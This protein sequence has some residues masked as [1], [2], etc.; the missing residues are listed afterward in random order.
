MVFRRIARAF[1]SD[2]T[3]DLS[4]FKG[5]FERFQKIL[6]GNNRVLEIMSEL[7]DKL[8][9]DYIFDINYLKSITDELSEEVN[10]IV[11]NLNVITDNRNQE[12]FPRQASVQEELRSI[13]HGSAAP[14]EKEY[15]IEYGGVD[16]DITEMVGGKNARLGEIKNQ[17]KMA[18]PDGFVLTTSAFRRFM[19]FN[20]LWPEI[21]RIHST[22]WGEN[23]RSA[24]KYDR[25]V[26][27]LFAGTKLP[28]EVARSLAGHLQT[29]RRRRKGA[30][31]L[32]V[33]S[34]AFG[35]DSERQSYAGQFKSI[36][37][38]REEDVPSSYV[39]VIAS[40]FRY[41][42]T[43]YTKEQITDEEKLPMAV[44][45]QQTIP[46]SSAGVLYSVDPSGTHINCITI[47]A[48]YGFGSRVVEGTVDADYFR[49]SR[50][51][52]T[53]IEERR[54]GTKKTKL[55]LDELRGL[56]SVPVPEEKRKAACLT[57]DQAVELAERALLLE[58]YFKRPVDV[59]WCFDNGG[60]LYILQC[61][62]LRLSA[63]PRV[64]ASDLKEMLAHKPVIMRGRGLVA[65][66]GIAAGKTWRVEEDDD[67]AEFPAGA[68]AVTRYTTP[69]LTSIIRRAAAIIT[70]IGTSSGHMAT[71]AREFGVPTI[72]NTG[73][74]TEL[75]K[76]GEEVTV[77]A[78]ENI[79]YRGIIDELLEYKIEA[80]DVYRDLKEYQIL[81]R[82][83]RKISPLFLIN[84]SGPDFTAKNCRTY[85][86]IVRYCHEKAVQCLINLNISS[87]RFRGIQ[88]R[89]VKLPVPLDLSVIDL[90][91]GLHPD[92]D[93]GE[94]KAIEKIEST[95]L[96]AIL[97]G[98]TV[99]GVWSTQPTRLGFGDLVSS[100]TRYTM[101]DRAS[102]LQEPNLAVISANYT[103]MSLRLGYHFN[104]IDAYVS[105]NINDNYV[106][107]RFVGGVTETERRHLRAILIRDILEK[108]NFKANVSGD[109]V[110]ARL[111][112]REA[113]E[114][115][116]VLEEIGRLIG[117]SRQLDTQ[118]QSEKSVKECFRTFFERENSGT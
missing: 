105:E 64:R 66:R 106:Y 115:L 81:R 78:E 62:P 99:P 15:I 12:L 7:E 8:S 98:L 21:R 79:I 60:Q 39:K 87:R 35:E 47:S 19:E 32:A 86:D 118:M 72:V 38:C 107:F 76:E 51:N 67:P 113:K 25:A 63:K 82:L 59:E 2:R 102:E 10:R 13:L 117:F 41:S 65:Q 73:D 17:L 14:A 96:K 49:I 97:D 29:L 83:L 6:T 40:R 88:T 93:G 74:A 61:R 90:G 52:P 89:K 44:G 57:D 28:P 1:R 70:D 5:L 30:F 3:S 85:H 31:G 95:P 9:G 46:A 36:L 4:E 84:P 11:S 71:V 77:D 108:L 26:D 37:N 112:K 56:K 22:H 23:R 58:R 116:H 75:L 43:L 20:K 54:I 80:E 16:S 42:V 27:D 94:I 33:R 110:V 18:V 103:N 48:G 104:V 24:E 109:L 68:I 55:V 92:A 45:I 111:K 69:R 53:Q 100:L 50:L 34:S 91:G 114:I 101:S